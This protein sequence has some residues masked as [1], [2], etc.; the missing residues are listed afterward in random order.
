MDIAQLAYRVD[1]SDL[2]KAN[3]KLADNERAAGRA[4]GASGRLQRAWNRLQGVAKGLAAAKG[5]VVA[6]L[7]AITIRTARYIQE[8]ALMSQQIG[9]T[10]QALSSMRYAAEQMA[11]VGSGQ[12]DMALRRMTRRIT[13]AA[14]GGGPAAAAIEAM[15]LSARELARL[16]PDEQFRRI[17]DAM[18]NT[19]DQGTRLRHTMA[20]MDTEGMPLVNMLSQG[21]EAI[22]EMEGEAEELGLTLGRD[23]IRQ[24]E[25]FR[26]TMARVRAMVQGM[27]IQVAS[28]LL[29]TLNEFA[30]LLNSDGFKQGFQTIVQGAVTAAQK[31]AEFAV[32]TAN[33]TTF[34]AEEV[35]ARI[36]GAAAD[37]IV[38]LEQEAE[39]IRKQLE[40]VANRPRTAAVGDWMRDVIGLPT[41]DELQARLSQLD[42]LIRDYYANPPTPGPGRKTV[43]DFFNPT[44][45]DFNFDPTALL[46]GAEAADLLAEANERARLSEELLTEQMMRDEE[47]RIGWLTRIDD[48]VARAEGP[49]AVAVLNFRRGLAELNAALTL[50]H[51][52]I[53]EYNRA[54]EAMGKT[55][56][57]VTVEVDTATGKM[58]AHADQAARNMQSA[59]ADF[60]FDP[61]KDGLGG[62]VDAFANA[63]RRMAA[64]MAASEVFK[65]LG[66]G[67]SNSSSGWMQ[68]LGSFFGGGR[69]H[70]G[71]VRRDRMYEVNEG[72]IP[73]LLDT[74]SRR[75]L[76]PG[77]DG[78]VTPLA[79]GA[80]G[81]SVRMAVPPIN[82]NVTGNANIETAS[83]RQNA[84]GGIDIEM[85][86]NQVDG[87]MA[88]RVMDGS[89]K[90]L[91]ALKGR[92]D[93]RERV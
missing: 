52:T 61:F 41:S 32:T 51:I 38:R 80:G 48:M 84:S 69:R 36:H 17:A 24:A 58:S 59:F 23:T 74:G 44:N 33:V 62:M 20:L 8:V 92:L 19:S 49:V 10:T 82:I 9:V 76:L 66:Q 7:T 87:M 42:T 15:G 93:V 73:E 25:E 60:L 53:E 63:L 70:G 68:A 79:S 50:G 43:E 29:P 14:A 64:E 31:L 37:D 78:Q 2:D 18:R 75:Y 27:A 77:G 86:A 85:V 90:T 5:L 35:A 56:G 46:A 12:F 26:R 30:K 45:L 3:A 55:L 34:L 21:A 22:R 28:N 72:G 65:M 47:A 13:E 40:F 6:G 81:G 11:N 16:S 57:D 91:A 83:V 39:R 1:S 89:S 71:P 88:G 54:A 4:E 67:L